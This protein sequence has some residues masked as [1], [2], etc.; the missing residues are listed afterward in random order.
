MFDIVPPKKR[1]KITIIE[2]EVIFDISDSNFYSSFCRLLSCHLINL[3]TIHIIA[4]LKKKPPD[5][6]CSAPKV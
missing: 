5:Q 3:K 4:L 6:S 2:W 1:I